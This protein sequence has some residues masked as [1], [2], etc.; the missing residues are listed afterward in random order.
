MRWHAHLFG[1]LEEVCKGR[2]RGLNIVFGIRRVL[3]FTCDILHALEGH[4]ALVDALHGASLQA[5]DQPAEQ[6]AV[7][8]HLEEV[9]HVSGC[10]DVLLGDLLDPLEALLRQLIAVFGVDLWNGDKKGTRN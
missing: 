3:E 2:D 7:L 10:A 9:L 1:H 4:F 8:E 5:V 6:G